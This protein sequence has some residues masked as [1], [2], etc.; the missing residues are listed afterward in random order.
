MFPGNP[1][2]L[3]V[4]FISDWFIFVETFMKKVFKS[5]LMLSALFFSWPHAAIADSYIEKAG[6][7]L[8][9]GF[10]NA[11]SGLAEIPKTILII[12]RSEGPIYGATVGLM[13]GILHTV[14]RTLYGTLDMATFMIPT[15]PLVDP[16][17]IWNDFDRL[18]NYKAKVQM[19]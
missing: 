15:K 1:G 17:Y 18:T 13:A 5:L 19:R 10:V 3:S 7:K 14:G 9:N 6:G 8:G 2:T 11:V 16:D 4:N 12:S